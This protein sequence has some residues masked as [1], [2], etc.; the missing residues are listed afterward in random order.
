VLLIAIDHK[1]QLDYPQTQQKSDTNDHPA[2]ITIPINIGE[3]TFTTF[4][5]FNQRG[6][7][8]HC[9]IHHPSLPTAT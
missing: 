4:G 8:Q 6:S 7:V 5:P 9:F 1:L 2:L 3:N